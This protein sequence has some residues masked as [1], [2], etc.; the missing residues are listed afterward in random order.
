[1][2]DPG[3]EDYRDQIL[4]CLQQDT[5]TYKDQRESGRDPYPEAYRLSRGISVR[6]NLGG[7]EKNGWQGRMKRQ[8]KSREFPEHLTVDST[9]FPE[10]PMSKQANSITTK[11]V[12][13]LLPPAMTKE[14]LLVILEQAGFVCMTDFTVLYYVQGKQL[15]G[16]R[17]LLRCSS[18]PYSRCYLRFQTTQRMN[19]FITKLDRSAI[20]NSEGRAG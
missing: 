17:H 1:M 20:P 10:R 12:V 13:R 3:V 9:R 15:W 6:S 18:L 7:K 8:H 11:V 5:T 4:K 2:K 14:E 16:R 19:E